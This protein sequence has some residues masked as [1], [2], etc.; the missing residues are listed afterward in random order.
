MDEKKPR[1]GITDT[2]LRDAHQSL[3]ATRMRLT[4]ILPIAERIDEIGYHSVE[5]WGGATFDVCMR[6]LNEDPWDRLHRIRERFKHTKI[7]MLLRGQNL[8]AYRNYADDLLEEFIKRGVA[9]GLDI[10]RIFDALND[11]RNMQKAIEITRREG[12]HAQGTICYTISPVH[13]IDHFVET[14][15][16]LVDMGSDSICI[17]DMSGILAP[18]K[19]F[20]LVERLKET[21]EVPIQ[22]HC[23]ASTGMA[24][25]SYI[26]AIEA[27]ADVVD[28]AAAPLS[29]YTSQPAVESMVASLQDTPYQLDLDFDAIRDV[30]EYFEVVSKNRKLMGVEQPIIDVTVISH[31]IPGGMATNL[32]AQL[33]QQNAL[34]RME[35]VLEE[36]PIVRKDMGYPPL[37]TPTS[38]LVGTQAVFNVLLGERYKIIPRE[39][40]NYVKG[41]Y[42]RP[43]GPI[44]EELKRRALKGED[45]ITCR[46]ADM[47]EPELPKA[48][49]ELNPDLVE[50]EED[51]ISYAIFPDIALKFFR[52]RKNPVIDDEDAPLKQMEKRERMFLDGSSIED[53]T[54]SLA[55]M[56][57]EGVSQAL[58][59]LSITVSLGGASTGE[60]YAATPASAPARGGPAARVDREELGK[61]M[62]RSPMVGTF[63]ATP[64]PGAPP[65]VQE[66]DAVEEGQTLC[67]IEVMKLFNE[68]PSP[69]AGR[70]KRI[71][72]RHGEGVEYDEIIMEIEPLG[73]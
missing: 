62:V 55:V 49:R 32:I 40:E 70:V 14:A 58:Q 39:I 65:Y 36:I 38:Q 29:L 22:L 46:P 59:N 68:I 12:A 19:A 23:H 56:V 8:V 45:P 41:Y 20:E 57:S 63:Y 25:N 17:K 34:D 10:I 52:W 33:E 60:A 64:S 50:K 28:C 30:S 73:D 9:G 51:F 2:T 47:L 1:V 66:G 54:E 3:W 21:V 69:T 27:G 67:L 18:Y 11:T 31:Q 13:D 16:E 61:L 42:G 71:L 6:Y 24:S 15:R 7:Q 5:V 48:K 72:A 4:D 37:V 43:A 26:K 53:L 35:E 44:D